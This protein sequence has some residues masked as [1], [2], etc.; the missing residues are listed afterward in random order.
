[1][2]ELLHVVQLELACRRRLKAQPLRL[3]KFVGDW[4]RN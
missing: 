1:M 3:S 2:R 4:V